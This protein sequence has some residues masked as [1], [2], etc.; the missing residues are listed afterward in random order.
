MEFASLED[1][2]GEL[3]KKKKKSKSRLDT[4]P[5][6]PAVQRMEQLQ[7]LG[8]SHHNQEVDQYLDESQK[9]Q[10][11][12]TVNNSLP[13]PRTLSGNSNPAPS[14]FGAEPFTNPA[15]DT[16]APYNNHDSPNG[17]M[18]ESDFTKSFDQAGF[19]KSSG[20][21]LPIPELRHRW[22]PLS[23]DNVESAFLTDGD[24]SSE[25]KSGQ[26][27]GMDTGDMAAMRSKLDT[28][29]ARLDDLEYRASGANPQMEMLSFIMTGLF[30]MFVLD[31]TVRK[32]GR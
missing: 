5:D 13:A 9:F 26:F 23:I 29:M 27:A 2:Y 16:K 20:A 21:S 11:R 15:E 18:L 30:L 8:Q 7:A 14:F 19:G 1:A 6:R 31:L 24:R 12:S 17:Y 4:D 25:R 22:K 32:S 3:P 10:N 28:L